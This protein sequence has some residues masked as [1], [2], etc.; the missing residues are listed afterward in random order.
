MFRV[1]VGDFQTTK[2]MRTYINEVLDNNRITYGPFCDQFERSLA[3]AH[4]SLHGV[5]SN[6]GTSSLQVAL[7]ALKERDGWP[8]D[9]EVI[10]P[11]TT[12]VATANVVLHNNM[13]PVPVDVNAVSY[14]MDPDLLAGALSDRTVAIIPVHLFGQPADMTSIMEFARGHDLGVIEDSCEAVRATHRGEPVGSFGDI[15]CFS[16]YVAHHIAAGVGGVGITR[17]AELAAIMRSLVNHGRDGVY[18]KSEDSHN[19]LELSRRFRFERLGHSFRIT[20]FEAAIALAQLATLPEQIK[21]RQL[22]AD[23]YTRRLEGLPL[24]LPMTLAGNSHS[25][26][27]YPIVCKRPDRDLLTEYLEGN[28]VETRPMLPLISQPVYQGMWD[29][30]DYPVSSWIDR[31]GF[32]IGCHPGVSE[33]DAEYVAATIRSFYD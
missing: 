16:L 30:E 11:A 1:G 5:L 20:E 8:D 28:G 7:Q 22:I 12:F 4:N 2:L 24:H 31:N 27:M 3:H 23:F 13:V 18:I 6:S 29:P 9:S 14:N 17:D 26:M 10:V 25:W 32:Y 15:G 21:A 19:L 33:E